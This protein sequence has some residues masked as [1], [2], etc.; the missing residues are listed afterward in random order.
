MALEHK[1][2]FM[3]DKIQKREVKVA[4]CPM[5]NILADVFTKPLQGS[6]FEKMWDRILNLPSNKTQECVCTKEKMTGLNKR[7]NLMIING[8]DKI[9]RTKRKNLRKEEN[10]LNGEKIN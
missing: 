2:L 6:G 1:M 7:R 5:E 10:T 3:A 8:N 9:K 4:Y